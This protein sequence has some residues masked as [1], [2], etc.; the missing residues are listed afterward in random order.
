VSAPHGSKP[1]QGDAARHPARCASF[2]ES[3]ML[4]RTVQRSM[5]DYR[6][7]DDEVPPPSPRTPGINKANPAAF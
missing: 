3:E 4:L 5:A 1:Q 2:Y 6:D 7:P